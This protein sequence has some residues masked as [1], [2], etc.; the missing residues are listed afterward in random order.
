[1]KQQITHVY[2]RVFTNNLTNVYKR[3]LHL[4]ITPPLFCRKQKHQWISL[5]DPAASAG[6]L[7]CKQ[8]WT[9]VKCNE[10]M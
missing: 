4:W 9:L 6:K 2:K 3:L 5:Q 1:L 7:S 10:S 8:T